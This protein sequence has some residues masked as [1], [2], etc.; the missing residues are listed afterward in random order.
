MS[1]KE[2]KQARR[3]RK[4]GGREV[5]T[6]KLPI[7]V[8]CQQLAV[9]GQKISWHTNRTIYITSASSKETQ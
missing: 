2:I 4:K 3:R 5:V 1:R 8:D 9:L 7:Q 6:S